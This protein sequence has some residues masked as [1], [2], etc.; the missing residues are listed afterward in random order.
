MKT[1]FIRLFFLVIVLLIST[2]NFAQKKYTKGYVLKE[3]GDTLMGSFSFNDEEPA[4]QKIY[5]KK[6][7]ESPKI[8]LDLKEFKMLFCNNQFYPIRYPNQKTN[9]Q[10]SEQK[11][12]FKYL[13]RTNNKKLLFYMDESSNEHLY[14]IDKL[15]NF[16]YLDKNEQN[17]NYYKT[18]L[19]EYLKDC[20]TIKNELKQLYYSKDDI[21]RIFSSYEYCLQPTE[22]KTYQVP[23]EIGVLVGASLSNVNF[24]S[25][26]HPEYTETDY[27]N[28]IKPVF[29]FSF[30]YYFRGSKKQFSVYNELS[31]NAFK[32]EGDYHKE[33]ISSYSIKD[34]HLMMNVGYLKHSLQG[35]YYFKN[36]QNLYLSLGLT[37]IYP[38]HHD[39]S[40][41]IVTELFGIIT[42]T[43]ETAFDEL[44]KKYEIG[45]NAGFGYAVNNFYLDLRVDYTMNHISWDDFYFIGFS[46][47][48]AYASIGYFFKLKN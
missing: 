26:S 25:T 34:Y 4:P 9:R 44:E 22:S 46:R 2:S 7:F 6:S 28:S 5:F 39:S 8:I 42:Q 11:V 14:I 13:I 15:N 37:D 12:V 18:I 33:T 35:R 10:S 3:S 48:N 30:N 45:F 1:Q 31:Y 29:G 32:V 36:Q 27:T 19:T 47:L 41:E 17:T 20:S 40:K 43:E 24:Q 38:I 23:A 16:V 21:L